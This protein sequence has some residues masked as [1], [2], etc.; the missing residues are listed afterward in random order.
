MGMFDCIRCKCP[1][2][3]PFSDDNEPQTKDT[4]SQQLDSYEIREDG[5]LWHEEYDIE[6]QSNPNAEGLLRFAGCMTR[7]NKRWVPTKFTGSINFYGEGEDG[8]WLEYQTYFIGGI[9]QSITRVQK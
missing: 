7:V 6:D 2:P 4:P 8:E 9:M 1:L 5:T 3:V